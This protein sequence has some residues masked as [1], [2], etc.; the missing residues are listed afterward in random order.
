MYINCVNLKRQQLLD[1]L[2]NNGVDLEDPNAFIIDEC[3]GVTGDWSVVSNM[4]DYLE[5]GDMEGFG[6]D[7]PGFDAKTLTVT[8]VNDAFVYDLYDED[9]QALHDTIQDNHNTD[10][11][12][13]D[14]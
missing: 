13:I 14:D 10:I 2:V 9:G 6:I 3:E 7:Q 11:V 5:N 12:D 8:R 1:V 4:M